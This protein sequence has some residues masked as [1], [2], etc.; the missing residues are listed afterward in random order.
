[1]ILITYVKTCRDKEDRKSYV[2]VFRIWE[3][4]WGGGL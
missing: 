3:F 4:G 2:N 1:M